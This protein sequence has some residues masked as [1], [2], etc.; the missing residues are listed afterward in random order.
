VYRI[1]VIVVTLGA[2]AFI[3]ATI[4]GVLRPPVYSL[5]GSP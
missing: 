2:F 4:S 5:A 1:L 3:A